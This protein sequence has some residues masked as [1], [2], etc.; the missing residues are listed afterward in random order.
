M[1]HDIHGHPHQLPDP[2]T[3][4]ERARA[5]R[6]TTIV[7]A[8]ERPSEAPAVLA[9][10]AK[11]PSNVHLAVGLHPATAIHI[12][13][14]E[15]SR[16]LSLL[17]EFLPRAVAIG[18]IGLD[19]RAAVTDAEQAFQ[20]DVLEKQLALAAESRLPV[21][22]HSRRAQRQTMEVAIAFTEATGL[23]ALLHWFTASR[24]LVAIA[25]EKGVFI[26]AG[27][28]VLVDEHTEKVVAGIR[29]DRL[30]I[31]TDCPVPILPDGNEPARAADVAEKLAR[32]HGL[33]PEEFAAVMRRNLAA[34]CGLPESS[35]V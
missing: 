10:G 25:N 27:P 1:W 2:E 5:R 35:A 21:Q 4:I 14:E 29:L 32:I 3:A 17:P 33:D 7:A 24:K 30:L 31:E 12:G 16:E 8:T 6:V 9:L 26:S 22:L 20:K 11:Y 13:K 19:Y 28:T 23:P 34:Y 15:S 18:E